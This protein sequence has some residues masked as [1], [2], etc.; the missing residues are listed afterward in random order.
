MCEKTVRKVTPGQPGT[1]KLLEKYGKALVCV[2]YRY[3]S[4]HQKKIKTVELIINESPWRKNANRIPA[5]KTVFLQVA[6]GEVRIGRLIK[7][8]GGRWNRK[9]R[10]WELPYGEVQALGLEERMVPGITDNKNLTQ[11]SPPG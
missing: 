1:K 3:D 8:A 7:A 11:R 5:N 4:K 9:K 2:R 6:Y 10:L